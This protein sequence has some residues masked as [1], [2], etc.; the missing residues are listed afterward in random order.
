MTA[1]NDTFRTVA[2][3]PYPMGERFRA[4][5]EE[6]R[7]GSTEVV[8][9]RDLRTK[10]FFAML[11]Y[12]RTPKIDHLILACET[13]DT[14]ALVPVLM[15]FSQIVG[16]KR[17]S[18]VLPDGSVRPVGFGDALKGA[19]HLIGAILDAY[20]RER[21]VRRQVA[22]LLCEKR[23]E[24]KSSESKKLIYIKANPMGSAKVGGA[25]AHTSGVIGGLLQHGFEVD[26]ASCEPPIM[27][28]EQV[29]FQPVPTLSLAVPPL[30][31][32][33]KAVELNL[34]RQHALF[35]QHL[36]NHAEEKYGL[37][38]QRLSLGNYAGVLLS[39]KLSIPLILE[40]N[41]S[42][43]WIAENWGNGLQMAKLAQEI[44]NCNLR[45]AHVIVTVSEVLRQDLINRGVEE[46]RIIVYPNCVSTEVFSPERLTTAEIIEK[47]DELNI[48]QNAVVATFIGT[49]GQWHGATIFAKAIKLLSDQHEDALRACGL[50]F[51]LVGD[52][53]Q[54]QEVE[55]IL[56]DAKCR[57]IVTL[58]GKVSQDVAPIMLAISDLFV[59][60]HVPNEDGSAFF[61]SPTKLFEYLASGKPILASDLYQVGEVMAQSPTLPEIQSGA[62]DG[63]CGIRLKP[64]DEF[65]LAAALLW[66]ARNKGWREKA[67]M[68]GRELA[69][70]KYTWTHHVKAVLDGL[71]RSCSRD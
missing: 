29:R 70:S 25:V 68:R 28:P 5:I 23:I 7:Q 63:G 58:T 34:L 55:T 57:D 8:L 33:P 37:I 69:V 39:R 30:R 19:F 22:E 20:K 61:G 13:E 53:V 2:I 12:L 46:D 43:V 14:W 3:S 11:R 47:R 32:F 59:S 26:Y 18:A 51:L 64:K 1:S 48:P 6:D 67:G 4:V 65:E 38:Y 71:E 31:T 10:P 36:E 15:V 60:P 44:E 16:A 9:L 40:Y 24:A 35:V 27:V 50:H 66:A 54:R 62:N 52:G 42:E 49:F 45:H 56:A 21:I 41:G 17:V